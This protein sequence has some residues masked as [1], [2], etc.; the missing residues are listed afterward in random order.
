MSE[1]SRGD[2]AG[3]RV[4]CRLNV[5]WQLSDTQMQGNRCVGVAPVC[6]RNLLRAPLA[7]PRMHGQCAQSG[8][9]SVQIAECA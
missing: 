9:R 1:D 2:K 4:R 7:M 3:Q 6:V 5:R 8:S